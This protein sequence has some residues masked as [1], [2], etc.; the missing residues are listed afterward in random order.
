M[1]VQFRT[2][3][4]RVANPYMT[5]PSSRFFNLEYI[6]NLLCSG[7]LHFFSILKSFY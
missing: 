6:S 7:I 3:D 2:Q 4:T 5:K 1:Y